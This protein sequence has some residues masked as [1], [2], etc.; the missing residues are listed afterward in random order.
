MGFRRASCLQVFRGRTAWLLA[1][2]WMILLLLWQ[3]P[4]P[5]CH[6][7]ELWAGADEEAHSA[8]VTCECEWPLL[9]H[10]YTFHSA[11]R[12]SAQPATGWHLHW[13]MPEVDE[14]ALPPGPASSEL[15]G[16]APSV[17]LTGGQDSTFASMSAS[18]LLESVS[19]LGAGFADVRPAVPCHF[20]DSYAASLAMPLRLGI[21]RC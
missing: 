1:M 6:S 2:R 15:P 11:D 17:I 18:W 8:S 12:D 10:L 16:A 5:W 3:G 4:I 19:G 14:D 9:E 7:H 13:V 20:L 21:M